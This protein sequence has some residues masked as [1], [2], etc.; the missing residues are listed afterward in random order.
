MRLNPTLPTSLFV[1]AAS[2]ASVGLP[3]LAPTAT[4]AP[5]GVMYAIRVGGS[6]GG[7][8][9]FLAPFCTGFLENTAGYDEGVQ[10]WDVT[11]TFERHVMTSLEGGAHLGMLRVKASGIVDAPLTS[12]ASAGIDTASC[13]G[14]G[15][16][17]SI[18]WNDTMT[19][20]TAGTYRFTIELTSEVTGNP[21]KP[22]GSGGPG[23]GST[24]GIRLGLTFGLPIIDLSHTMGDGNPSRQT[25]TLVQDVNM[26]AGQ[27]LDL[28]G[29]LDTNLQAA[30]DTNLT[31]WNIDAGA[32]G[33]FYIDPVTEGATYT[34][35][36]GVSYSTPEP[37]SVP[38]IHP[39]ALY[40]LVVG[41]LVGSG[42]VAIKR[43]DRSAS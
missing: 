21:I 2:V 40:T 34:M 23:V 11:G 10:T 33:H 14:G 9:S 13:P 19:A 5:W 20:N 39:I 30:A 42:L 18:Q 16:A 36:S 3:S 4:A 29:W 35:A 31:T 38:S 6:A 12:G 37:T 27:T 8:A 17:N 28:V 41:L 7:P 24:N 25:Q 26:G 32:T 1:L 43:R 15:R 22:G